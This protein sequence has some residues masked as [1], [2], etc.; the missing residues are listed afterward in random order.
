MSSDIKRGLIIKQLYKKGNGEIIVSIFRLIE[1]IKGLIWLVKILYDD[2][3]KSLE[4]TV[5]SITDWS[6]EKTLENKT[7][8]HK[9]DRCQYIITEDELMVELL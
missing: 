5:G 9:T 6:L 8:L 1:N 4:Y 3:V 7:N 2:D